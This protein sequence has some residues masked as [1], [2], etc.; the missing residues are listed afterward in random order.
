M[1]KHLAIIIP[2]MF[3]T[4]VDAESDSA[5][6]VILTGKIKA[7]DV[8]NFTTPWSE[9]WRLQIKWMKPEGQMV[10]QGDLVV[11]FDTASL[12]TQIEQQKVSLRQAQEKAKESRLRLEQEVIDA[13]HALVKAQLEFQ[14]AK[15]SV[16]VPTKF[17]SDFEKDNIGFD[18]KK[19][20]K[21]LEQ[22][23][24]KLKTAQAALVAE[25]KKQVLEIKRIGAIL[26]KKESELAFM[27]LKALRKGTVLHAMHPWN[28][29][30]IT[31][32][33]SVQ[34]S[35]NVASI[36]GAGDESVRAWVNEVDWHKI[37]VG[38]IVTLTLDAF[39]NDHFKGKIRKVGQQAESKKEWGSA[40]Y[41][42]VDIEITEPSKH[43]LVP[44]M[45]V[46]VEIPE[47]GVGAE[48]NSIT[49]NS[50]AEKN[51]TTEAG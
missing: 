15:L 21:M 36:P 2:L 14:L 11:L 24:T 39:P 3:S 27:Q 6:S 28:G 22:A 43:S 25:E 13:E 45:S 4:V 47:N 19:A 46:R 12:D 42:D 8:Q 20:N 44:G 23:K 5:D 32:G 17:R 9:N 31:E 48:N 50:S 35:W 30:K 1:I 7:G 18:F 51:M 33:Q 41:Y 26:K 49:E 29:S 38:Q 16:N 37:G 40:T 34:T 10:E